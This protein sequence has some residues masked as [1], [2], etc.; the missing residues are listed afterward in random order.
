MSAI[1]LYDRVRIF[2]LTF[3]SEHPICAQ[4]D[5]ARETIFPLEPARILI[6][7]GKISG[8]SAYASEQRDNQQ[9]YRF[10]RG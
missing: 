1:V 10:K 9:T 8:Q 2:Q 5:P 3:D 4:R 7:L 6:R